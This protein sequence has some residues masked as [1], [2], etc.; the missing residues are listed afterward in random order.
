MKKFLSVILT[1]T[2]FVLSS[3]SAVACNKDD[4]IIPPDPDEYE[5]YREMSLVKP[6]GIGGD[7]VA[8]N[9]DMSAVTM[10]DTANKNEDKVA[11]LGYVSVGTAEMNM[12]IG[13]G[14]MSLD[15]SVFTHKI[16]DN[17]DNGYFYATTS[18][19]TSDTNSKIIEL[20]N[21][22]FVKSYY[23]DNAT[24]TYYFVE[25]DSGIDFK[26]DGLVDADTF[27]SVKTYS[28]EQALVDD[29]N[30]NN[31]FVYGVY[32]VTD[33][34]VTSQEKTH[35]EQ[36]GYWTVKLTLDVKTATKDYV[37]VLEQ[38]MKVKCVVDF[39]YCNI[40][41]QIWDNG[42]LKESSIEESY[43]MKLL[44]TINGTI[45]N[46]STTYYSYDTDKFDVEDYTNRFGF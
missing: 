18:S 14:G 37:K 12:G 39:K 31:P 32:Y 30:A 36:E 25:G 38:M 9:A 29:G 21:V 45:T 4:N 20:I 15:Q 35:N 19:V 13:K 27:K 23:R 26:D 42:L 46:A 34:T 22:C 2:M 16:I 44:N 33:E 7:Y 24:N 43:D 11:W 5:K 6:V 41:Y 1:L 17:S 8:L 28:S 10:F 40:E 3:V